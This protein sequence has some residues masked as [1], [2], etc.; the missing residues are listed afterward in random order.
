MTDLS[1][2]NLDVVAA[3]VA[4]RH[5]VSNATDRRELNRG[6]RWVRLYRKSGGRSA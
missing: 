5:R 2:Q 1:S 6:H 3:E 4:Y